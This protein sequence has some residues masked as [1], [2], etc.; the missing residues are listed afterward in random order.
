MQHDG[1]TTFISPNNSTPNNC[2]TI[3]DGNRHSI[4]LLLIFLTFIKS[5]AT[6]GWKPRYFHKALKCIYHLTTK[7]AGVVEAATAEYPQHFPPF[8]LQ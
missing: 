2:M 3:V 4:F 8:V 5:C 7:G 6:F 1:D